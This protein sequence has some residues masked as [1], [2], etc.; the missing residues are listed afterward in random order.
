MLGL[1]E[2]TFDLMT[3]HGAV[4]AVVIGARLF[5]SFHYRMA[6]FHRGFVKFV[7]DGISTVVPRAAL[8]RF[9]F[10]VRYQLQHLAGL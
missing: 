9:Y 4:A 2:S 3:G 8:D 6:Y 1:L 7:F 10:C 5:H